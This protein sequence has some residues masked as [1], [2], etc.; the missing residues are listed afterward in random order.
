M[1]PSIS[2]ENTGPPDRFDLSTLEG[3]V[4][5]I[6]DIYIMNKELSVETDPASIY[7]H[8]R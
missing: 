1:F 8:H 3:D 2:V 7:T 5:C 4:E 6:Y